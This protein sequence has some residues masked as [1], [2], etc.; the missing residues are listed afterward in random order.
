METCG[1]SVTGE[2]PQTRSVEDAHRP[3]RCSLS[4]LERKSTDN[5]DRQKNFL[6]EKSLKL[7]WLFPIFCQIPA[8]LQRKGSKIVT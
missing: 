4:I 8:N 3:P 2:T 5:I 6:Y 1:S 7:K